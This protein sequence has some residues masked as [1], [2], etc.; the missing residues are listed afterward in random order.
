MPVTISISKNKNCILGYSFL[1]FSSSLLSD[2]NNTRKI[3]NLIQTFH[4][5]QNFIP[6]AQLK[7]E[8]L[9]YKIRKFT[10]NYSIK[11]AKERKAIITLL[12]NKVRELEGNLNIENNIQPYNIYQKE[13]DSTYN[14]IAEGI[15]ILSKCD[16]Y[17]Y[18]EKSTKFFF[19]L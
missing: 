6:N 13:L 5:S 3:K 2:Q 12:Q 19:N 1:K 9:K 14:H 18:G 7:C 8:F 17:K 16:W 15:K 10:I 4:S 11:L